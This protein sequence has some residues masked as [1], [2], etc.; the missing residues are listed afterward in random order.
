M[1]R[2]KLPLAVLAVV[3]LAA[4]IS[5]TN[6]RQSAEEY[7]EDPTQD[8]ATQL[9]VTFDDAV[10]LEPVNKELGTTFECGAVGSDGATYNF[11]VEITGDRTFRVSEGA[12]PVP[13]TARPTTVAAV[14]PA[15]TA[16]A[17]TAPPAT[18]PPTTP[19]P[20]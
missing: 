8:V 20:S 6:F 13:G 10:C 11:T 4:C 5:Q 14:A 7:I 16:P 9:G 1:R 15:T 17:G 12:P 19:P 18:A 2:S 3:A